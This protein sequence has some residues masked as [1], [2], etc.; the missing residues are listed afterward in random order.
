MRD[1]HS[2]NLE[3]N[4]IDK[5]NKDRKVHAIFLAGSFRSLCLGFPGSIISLPVKQWVWPNQQPEVLQPQFHRDEASPSTCHH[6]S[7]K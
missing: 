4:R 3:L 5:K 2:R 1:E 7:P 6:D